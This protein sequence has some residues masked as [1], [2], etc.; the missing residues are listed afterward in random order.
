MG[1]GCAGSTRRT[2]TMASPGVT[3]QQ[4]PAAPKPAG[5]PGE[6]GYTWNGPDRAPVTTG[7]K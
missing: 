7:Q 6:P 4:A 5:G 1:C 3:V 2:A